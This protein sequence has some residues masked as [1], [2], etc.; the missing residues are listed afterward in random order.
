MR[1]LTLIT[2]FVLLFTVLCDSASAQGL[3]NRFHGSSTSAPAGGSFNLKYTNDNL[4]G[5]K[6]KITLKDPL[7][8]SQTK[9]VEVEVDSNG[10]VN[11]QI[12]VPV[13][14]HGVLLTGPDTR[15]FV[16]DVTVVLTSLGLA[17]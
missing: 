6:V 16:I 14:W 2:V 4:A 8:Q 1:F 7:D 5:T 3:P 15:D 13:G 11:E 17:C 12:P 9:E 10:E